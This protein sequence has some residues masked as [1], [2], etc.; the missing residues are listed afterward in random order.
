MYKGRT[1]IYSKISASTGQVA[2][3][4]DPEKS[5]NPLYLTE[6]VKKATFAHVAYFFVGGSTVTHREFEQCISLLKSLTSIPIVIF[7]GASHQI[8]PHADAL[9][10]LNLISGRNPDYLI[11][12]QV[13]AASELHQIDI[14]IIPTGYMLVD[15]G[16]KTSVQYVSQ[17]SPIPQD[18]FT[19]A[20]NT[21][22]AGTM[23]G[24][25]LLY[26]DAG[27]GAQTSVPPQW[28]SEI[29]HATKSPIIVGG[30]IRN[31]DQLIAYKEAQAN[32]IVI[33]NHIEENI[34]FL[35]DIKL[36][37]LKQS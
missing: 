14:E 7:P 37:C 36:F 20:K 9:L 35:T 26:F 22:L 33:G 16:R 1:N 15:G 34:D 5:L 13:Q 23:M 12:H 27:S 29:K 19:I 4:I 24:N 28:I 31:I 32:I 10:F 2:V 8:S 3:L 18:Q 25:Q 17:T 6:L 11:G 21:A 30:G